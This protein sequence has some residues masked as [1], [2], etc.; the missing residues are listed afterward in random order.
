MVDDYRTR[1]SRRRCPTRS[2]R[3]HGGRP[4]GADERPVP[5]APRW[6]RTWLDRVL[7]LPWAAPPRTAR[8]GGAAR[9]V[10]DADHHG[11]DDVK[12]RIV[13][14]L[15]VRAR[16]GEREACGRRRPRLRRGAGARR[17][18]RRRARP[19][20][21]SPSPAALGRNFVRVAL[22][23][24]RDEAEI[25]GH[26]RDLRRRLP[27][28]I[29]RAHHRGR[30]DEPGRAARRGRQARPAAGAA[31]PRPRCSRCSTRRRT[32]RSATTTSRSSL[33][34]SD[35][36]FI[37][38]ANVVDTIPPPCCDRMEADPTRRLHRGREGRHRR[39]LPAAPP[40][41]SAPALAARRGRGDRR[42]AARPLAADY[43]R[44]PVSA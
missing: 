1:W 17:P 39:A 43:T 10:L 41:S 11:L 3:L 6:I 37:A 33:D 26:R 22:G 14:F 30:L 31:T 36:V 9:A 2:R 7:E 40:A 32:T 12:D 34:L 29:V 13:E 25:R 21:A 44:R 15:A 8:P 38:T 5:G 4:A 19:A 23:G 16:R 27:G 35:V 24:V 20:S 42:R 18:A 28:R